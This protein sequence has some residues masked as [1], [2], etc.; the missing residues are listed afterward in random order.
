M[1]VVLFG[2]HDAHAYTGTGYFSGKAAYTDL[3]YSDDVLSG[4][5]GQNAIPA[6][7]KSSKNGF[8]T[9]IRNKL[10]NGNARDKTGAAFIVNLMVGA[11]AGGGW[12]KDRTPSAAM[13]NDWEAR[14]KDNS[15][16][17]Y[18]TFA[19][20]NNYGRISFYDG[21]INDD[22]FTNYN[23]GARELI[24]FAQ[25]GQVKAVIEVPCANPIGRSTYINPPP[26]NLSANSWFNQNGN[27]V[28]EV[29]RRVGQSVTFNHQ[30]KNDGPGNMGTKLDAY[31]EWNGGSGTGASKS[32][33]TRNCDVSGGLN[34]NQTTGNSCDHTFT[35][36]QD[37]SANSRYCQRVVGSPRSSTNNNNIASSRICVVVTPQWSVVGQ[38]TVTVP[39]DKQGLG[40]DAYNFRHR[41]TNEGPHHMN[42]AGRGFA[43][44]WVQENLNNSGWTD[45]GGARVDMVRPD[46]GTETINDAGTLPADFEA[47]DRYCQRVRVVFASATGNQNGNEQTFP[48]DCIDGTREFELVPSTSVNPGTA[49][50]SGSSVSVMPIVDNQGPSLSADDTAW[51]LSRFVLAP[52]VAVP[53]TSTGTGNPCVYYANGCTMM[54]QGTGTFQVGNPS[55]MTDGNGDPFGSQGYTIPDPSP[56]GTKYCFALSVRP[57]SDTSTD[58][59]YGVPTCVTIG[60]TPK[61]AVWGHDFKTQGSINTSLSRI[62]GRTYG[63][64]GEY[65]TLSNGANQGMASGSGLVD[66]NGAAN[67]ESWSNLTFANRT[68][69]GLQPFGSYGAVT[70]FTVNQS[71]AVVINGDVTLPGSG[72]TSPF[73]TGYKRVVRINGT[74][75]ISNN[76]TYANGPY[77]SI[78]SIPRVVLIAEDIIIDPNVTRI[79]TWLVA[80]RI[81]TCSNVTNAG[82]NFV[83]P[84]SVSMQANTCPNP[85]RFNGPVVANELYPYRTTNSGNDTDTVGE[86]FNLRADAFLS[87][88]AGGGINN[89]VASTDM[90]TDLPPRF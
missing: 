35:I 8:T 31:A 39:A 52:G 90:V 29:S 68:T 81:A 86:T 53:G 21:S 19:D 22:F 7:A 17:M 25:G 55:T 41:V 32:G 51:H 87:A 2:S 67:Q 62:S 34:N 78:S 5:P 75:R 43:R 11:G 65:G 9:F 14:I 23:S 59:R 46:G 76:L 37:A 15:V 74:L 72:Y 18:T 61:L 4:R 80:N 38:T 42:S 12:S 73:G 88:F 69:G 56:V 16:S 44:I 89:P 27:K 13:L 50:E 64:W 3:S 49:A 63:S 45:K 47:G 1:G 84:D 54:S 79:D 6:G 85:L 77:S 26:F 71:G 33:R 48:R 40:G 36:P 58:W 60:I 20:P 24:V 70:N 57:Y 66:G 28:N 82:S 10:K 30:I 83:S